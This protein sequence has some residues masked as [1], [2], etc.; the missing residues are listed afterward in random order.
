MMVTKKKKCNKITLYV[1]SVYILP[2]NDA[3]IHFYS[4]A[5]MFSRS[6]CT[7]FMENC[8]AFDLLQICS[9]VLRQIFH[10]CIMVL[11]LYTNVLVCVYMCTVLSLIEFPHTSFVSI[12]VMNLYTIF[13]VFCTQISPYFLYL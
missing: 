13:N 5:V 3:R 4:F 1:A 10:S 2:F 7:Y 9:L 6:L 11:L 12:N 8:T